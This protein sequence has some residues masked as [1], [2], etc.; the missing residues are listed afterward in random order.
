VPSH[1]CLEPC[2]L[3]RGRP[4]RVGVLLSRTFLIGAAHS[5]FRSTDWEG[6]LGF[7]HQP[8]LVG[9]RPAGHA[10]SSGRRSQSAV[11]HSIPAN[12]DTADQADT[13]TRDEQAQRR[14]T[15]RQVF[16]QC[17]RFRTSAPPRGVRSWKP[18][19]RPW[20]PS[21]GSGETKYL[22]VATNQ[23]SSVL[24]QYTVDINGHQSSHQRELN[25]W[26][27]EGSDMEAN[28]PTHDQAD[29]CTDPCGAK[30]ASSGLFHRPSMLGW[31]R[32]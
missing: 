24:S 15:V 21:G 29:Q 22:L 5:L 18:R 4:V 25:P 23:S 10:G 14:R 13:L 7:L 32:T 20:R 19:R 16:R 17:L 26:Q 12:G 9:A 2:R 8:R 28:R 31:W 6:A 27:P 3:L 30:R 11:A 1:S